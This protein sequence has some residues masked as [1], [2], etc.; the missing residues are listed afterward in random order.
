[1]FNLLIKKFTEAFNSIASSSA[2]A[3]RE[4]LTLLTGHVKRKLMQREDFRSLTGNNPPEVMKNNHENHGEFM[5]TMFSLKDGESFIKTVLWVYRSYISRGFSPAYFSVELLAWRGA[6]ILHLD[7]TSAS[8]IGRVYGLMIENHENFL[9][10]SS[11]TPEIKIDEKFKVQ[12][13][14]YLKALLEGNTAEAVKVAKKYVKNTG[15]IPSFWLKVLEPAMYKIGSLWAEGKITVGQEHL[16]SSITQRVMVIFYPMILEI[17]KTG[18]SALITCSKGE[19]HKI[20]SQ[21]VSDFLEMKGWNVFY[22][23]DNTPEESIVSFLKTGKINCLGISTTMFYNIPSVKSLIEVIK[24]ECKNFPVKVILGGQ[25]YS[26]NPRIWK[27]I[28]SD[29]YAGNAEEAVK[30]FEELYL[31]R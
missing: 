20:G 17:P 3:Y 31:T 15:D 2:D 11:E 13:E 30:V 19:L 12:Y 1:M 27:E 18:K 24:K 7:N 16:A 28:G 14:D 9:L 23:G 10:L 5:S 26:H 4:K 8:D 22:M 21:I 6:V 29:G 25:A